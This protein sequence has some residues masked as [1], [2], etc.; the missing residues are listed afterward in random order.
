MVKPLAEAKLIEFEK[1]VDKG[2]KIAKE[3]GIKEANVDKIV[4]KLRGITI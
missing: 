4:H 2:V 1:L 3:H